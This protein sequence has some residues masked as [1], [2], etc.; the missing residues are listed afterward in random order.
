MSA[1][2]PN[3]VPVFTVLQD[4]IDWI[5]AEHQNVP[6]DEITALATMTGVFGAPQS[7]STDFLERL[8]GDHVELY[9]KWIDVATLEVQPGVMVCSNAS[10]SVRV[11]RK[12]TAPKTVTFAD[13]DTGSEQPSTLYYLYAVADASGTSLAFKISTSPTAPSGVTIFRRMLKFVND[14][15]SNIDKRSVVSD[16]WC[17]W[18]GFTGEMRMWGGTIATIPQGW[19]HCDFSEISRTLYTD[20]FDAVGEDWGAG[21]TTTTFNIPETRD[22]FPVGAQTD[23]GAKSNVD[24]SMQKEGGD[25][26]QPPKTSFEPPFEAHASGPNTS[27]GGHFHTFVPPFFSVAMIIKF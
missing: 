2:I 4:D 13:I 27:T 23:A 18:D 8:K 3:S 9:A 22:R 20:L 21:D 10:G 16:G 11:A 15:S 17:P 5:L 25:L 7:K 1:A 26:N 19:G 24:G 12:L 14:G 6:N